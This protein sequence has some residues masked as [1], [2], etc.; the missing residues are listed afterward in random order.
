MKCPKCNAVIDNLK[1]DTEHIEGQD[2]LILYCPK[3][4]VILSV[5]NKEPIRTER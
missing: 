3:C 1:A 5:L 2:I 4:E